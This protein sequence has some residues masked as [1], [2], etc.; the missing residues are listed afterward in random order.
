MDFH[1]GQKYRV[2]YS[3]TTALVDAKVNTDNYA[4][5]V[6]SEFITLDVVTR[7]MYYQHSWSSMTLS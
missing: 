7:Y 1:D 4:T 6:T 5:G 3:T 2:P